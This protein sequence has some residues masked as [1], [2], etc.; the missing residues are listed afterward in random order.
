MKS[1][2]LKSMFVCLLLSA[3]PLSAS[4]LDIHGGPTLSIIENPV[5]S[6]FSVCFQH[7]CAEVAHVSL[8]Q[9]QWQH[10]RD[11]FN[12]PESSASA[13]EERQRIADAI[14]YLEIEVG[15][16]IDSLDDRGGNLEGFVAEG[17]Q[18]DCVDE[19]TNSTTYLTMMQDDG[20]L[21][22]H[23]VSK[24]ATRGFMIFG[25]PHTTA[26]IREKSSGQKWVVDSWFFDNGE[27]PT[28]AKIDKWRTGWSPEGAKH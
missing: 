15:K 7:T 1:L 12:T 25:W 16:Q 21:K 22:F 18:L 4:G 3:I 17:N 13:K 27:K 2:L 5:P 9:K 28:I 26:V 19:S 24:K 20:L 6:R 11:I 10:I 14:S 8:N 23:D